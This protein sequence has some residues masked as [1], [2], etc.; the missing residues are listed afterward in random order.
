MPNKFESPNLES[1]KEPEIKF[2]FTFL[3][4]DLA[5]KAM[6]RA[7]EIDRA[8][9]F[10]MEGV[11]TP[12][13]KKAIQDI[14]DGIGEVSQEKDFFHSS[15]EFREAELQLLKGTQKPILFFDPS[16]NNEL[17][18]G[19]DDYEMN[20][21]AIARLFEQGK[22]NEAMTATK[23]NIFLEGELEVKREKIMQQQILSQSKILVK[24]YPKLK[25]LLENNNDINVIIVIGEAHTKIYRNMKKKSLPVTRTHSKNPVVY[26]Y[27]EEGT[28]RIA[29]GMELSDDLIARIL[30]EE[31]VGYRGGSIE[32]SIEWRKRTAKFSIEDIKKI[33]E[34]IAGGK[35]IQELVDGI[36]WDPNADVEVQL[37][38]Y[39]DRVNK[40]ES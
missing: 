20:N 16:I 10:G 29:E 17:W 39:Y 27:T 22:F 38:A 8:D 3:E 34:S 2:H 12:R 36:D 25:E 5:E 4:H 26:A 31:A 11:F 23:Q 40:Q 9:I 7:D 35:K 33:S 32:D 6:V 21:E 13:E 18:S 24:K 37:K 30:L 1:E 15:G 19:Y 28:R 14:S